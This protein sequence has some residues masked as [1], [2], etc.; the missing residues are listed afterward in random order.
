MQAE[1][2]D[3]AMA[4]TISPIGA[5]TL[6][7]IA[8]LTT[9][10]H[11][12]LSVYVDLDPARFPTPAER[13]TQ[14]AA[15]LGRARRERAGAD[16]DRVQA[17]LEGDR[18][19]MREAGALAIFSSAEAD[20]LEAVHLPGP[21][22]PLAVV[23]SVPHL[24]PIAAMA[25]PGEWCVA[26]VCRTTGRVLRGGCAGLEE[27]ASVAD[28]VHRQHS[29]GGWSQSRFSRG[30]DEQVH[31]HVERVA[32]RLLREHEHRAFDHLVI[33]AGPEVRPLVEQELHGALRAVLAG[34]VD[35]DMQTASVRE[36]ERAVA[37][38]MEDAAHARERRLL[39]RLDHGLGTGD[40]AA[41]GLDAVLEMLA[42]ER[43]GCLLVA[44]GARLRAMRCPACGRL[45]AAGTTTCPD[46]GNAL[47]EV[48]GTEHVIDAA[49]ARSVEVAVV[50]REAGRLDPHGGIA[51]LLRW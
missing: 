34:T 46:D 37:P 17:L 27:V 13:E 40:R 23:D 28:E 31:W 15:L 42:Q 2:A 41:A 21:V 8:R 16:A 24:E 3:T 43:V 39:D 20:V 33:V 36:I 12:V 29:Q 5:D 47:A 30:I 4:T 11:P 1:E 7:R 25:S 51:A 32:E 50:R 22:E 6:E 38:L 35:V 44:E 14:L 45:R 9:G 49:A 48:D 10:G 19:T 26:V 18:E